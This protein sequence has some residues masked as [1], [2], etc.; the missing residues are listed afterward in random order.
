MVVEFVPLA[1]AVL[2]VVLVHLGSLS[3]R[4]DRV[5][6]R[7]AMLTFGPFSVPESRQSDRK[8]RLR[9]AHVPATLREYAARTFLLS[10]V[11]GT[12][13]ALGAMYAAWAALVALVPP[14]TDLSAQLPAA[15]RNV[16]A[17]VGVTVPASL[18]RFVFSVVVGIV[19]GLLVGL[20][21]YA[22]RWYYP[23]FV[24]DERAR[25]I[26]QSLP[27]TVSFM[28]ALS[29]SGMSFT[30]VMRIL[31]RNRRVYGAA[32]DEV[33]VA[34]RNVDVF[35][36]DVVTAVE[37]MG[38]RSPSV[39]FRE[40]SENLTSV[41]R[42]GGSLAEFLEREYREFRQEA[43]VRQERLLTSLATYAEAYAAVG[44]ALPLF[45]MVILLIVAIGPVEDLPLLAARVLVY[46]FIPLFNVAFVLYLTSVVDDFSRRELTEEELSI[47]I[48]PR[49]VRRREDLDAESVAGGRRRRLLT[50]GGGNRDGEG[51]AATDGGTADGRLSPVDRERIRENRRRLALYRRLQEVRDRV[52][53]PLR[54]VL[55]EPTA[56]LWVSVP[57]A[58]LIL[59]LR[60]PGLLGDGA[61]TLR[62]FD[63]IVV[64]SLLL[65]TGSF[66]LV[67]EIHRRRVEAVESVVP[68]FL[69]RLA[70][71]NEAGMTVVASM[72]RIRRSELGRLNDELNVIW[73]DVQWGADL[74]TALKRFD[75]RMRTTMIS[76]VVTLITESMRA[77]GD[78][79]PVLR[80]AAN[81]AKADRRLKRR[82]RD[83]M[84]VYIVFV[85][86]G[87]FVFLAIVGVVT[88]VLL[89][90]LPNTPAV[91][92]DQAA[93]VA[94]GGG[95]L[96]GIGQLDQ[97]AWKLTLIHAVI[98]QGLFSGLLAGQFSTGD[99]RAGAKHVT[100]L[101]ALG[102]AF[103]LFFL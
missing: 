48:T 13:A 81:R 32:A 88:V 17:A 29:R 26:E 35:N 62:E 51:P 41:L 61:L 84:V 60:I 2:A 93:R 49:G 92:D 98:V 36:V 90:N 85:Y 56:L 54:T 24:A 101:V 15:L 6:T 67:Y 7:V 8:A 4:T 68:D 52:G 69:D 18:E 34:V 31:A 70:S 23:K 37:T 46:G 83:E 94:F 87:F 55:R 1:V 74:Q 25:Q 75:A 50:T 11:H 19:V 9:S 79:G 64:Q 78:I 30:E 96:A 72:N 33:R 40:L 77:S 99:L 57:V 82:R 103:V 10:A 14:D 76:R 71:L 100:V 102:Y 89:P 22:Y 3:I 45:G 47:N 21:T 38:R 44:I 16:G 5:L 28:Y 86:I 12:A 66:A 80:I 59:G 53:S 58:I 20:G 73:R 27:M 39:N 42:T 65:V 63:D 95:G 91:A 43:E 97:A